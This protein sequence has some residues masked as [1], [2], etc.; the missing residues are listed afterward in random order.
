MRIIATRWEV[1]K[2][3]NQGQ[4]GEMERQSDVSEQS[5]APT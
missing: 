4:V 2:S 5:D 3:G 1:L